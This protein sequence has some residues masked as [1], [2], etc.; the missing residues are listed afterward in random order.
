M[1]IALVPLL[2]CETVKVFGEAVSVKF[3]ITVFSVSVVV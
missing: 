1:A 3:G 2:P